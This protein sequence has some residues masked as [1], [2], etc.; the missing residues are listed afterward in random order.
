MREPF[1]AVL[2]FP[3]REETV[4]D[5]GVPDRFV[6]GVA[7]SSLFCDSSLRFFG[8]GFLMPFGAALA[9]FG[10]GRFLLG[11]VAGTVLVESSSGLVSSGAGLALISDSGVESLSM[12]GFLAARRVLYSFCARAMAL[13]VSSSV[14]GST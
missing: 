9:L 12:T 11:A 4:V 13:A 1:F 6:A 2:D 5:A 10:A 8:G 3:P 7:R 14:L